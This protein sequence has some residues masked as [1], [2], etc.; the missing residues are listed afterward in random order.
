MAIVTPLYK[1]KGS[2][3]DMNN[4]RGISVLT[5]IGKMFEKIV[6]TQIT[7]HFNINNLFFDGQHGFRTDHS[8][9]TAL[10]ELLSIIND[11]K[12]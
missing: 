3:T 10:H 8:C 6:A 9:E 1:N 7:T 4:Y 11:A 5:P 2:P 12:N